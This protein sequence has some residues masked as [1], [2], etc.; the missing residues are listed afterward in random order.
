MPVLPLIVTNVSHK[1]WQMDT[2]QL[3][4]KLELLGPEQYYLW[5]KTLWFLTIYCNVWIKCTYLGNCLLVYTLHL[6]NSFEVRHP[7][8][9][10]VVEPALTEVDLAAAVQIPE[11]QEWLHS[12]WNII[13]WPIIIFLFHNFLLFLD[14]LKLWWQRWNQNPEVF[15]ILNLLTNYGYYGIKYDK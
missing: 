10:L 3:S 5:E 4:E 7:G 6:S 11:T 9:R 13:C 12:E 8:W 1:I 15:T 14:F 2:T